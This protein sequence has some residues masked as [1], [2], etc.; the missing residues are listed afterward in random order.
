MSSIPVSWPS[1]QEW[2][3]KAATALN[4]LTRIWPDLYVP[5]NLTI[6]PGSSVT[7]ASNGDLVVEAT[8]N[9][10]VTIKLKGTD[11]TVRSVSLTLV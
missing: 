5:G 6:V 8:S 1:F 7:P 11:G 3:R 2:M 10:S 4:P 9:T